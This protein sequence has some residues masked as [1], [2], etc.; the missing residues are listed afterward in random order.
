MLNV[1][2]WYVEFVVIFLVGL[3]YSGNRGRGLDPV[4]QVKTPS[5]SNLLLTVPRRYFCCGSSMLHVMSVCAC[6][7]AIW[8]AE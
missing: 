7:S 3:N 5:P 6:S 2:R 8:S 4:K 1:L